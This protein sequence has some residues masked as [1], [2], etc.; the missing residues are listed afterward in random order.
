MFFF[1]EVLVDD[2]VCGSG[3]WER[4]KEAGF[5]DVFPV[6]DQEVLEVVGEGKA[7]GGAGGEGVFL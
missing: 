3:G 2:V 5:G 7:D 6:V 1:I 4:D